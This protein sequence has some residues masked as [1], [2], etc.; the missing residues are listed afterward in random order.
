M[1]SGRGRI[2]PGLF[3]PPDATKPERWADLQLPLYAAM[4][5]GLLEHP[6]GSI[7]VGYVQLPAA[8]SETAIEAWHGFGP[9]WMDEAVAC[10]GRV[11][12]A[13]RAKQ[14]LDFTGYPHGEHDPYA[15]LFGGDPEGAVDLAALRAW[16]ATQPPGVAP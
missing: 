6:P 8:V 9:R 14:F 12:A 13:I 3:T 1:K 10:A 7:Q 2:G 5:S 16:G 4:V 15:S 11:E